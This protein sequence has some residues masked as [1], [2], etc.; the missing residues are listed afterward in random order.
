MENGFFAIENCLNIFLLLPRAKWVLFKYDVLFPFLLHFWTLLLYMNDFK[1]ISSFHFSFSDFEDFSLFLI[2]VRGKGRAKERER[3]RI[4]DM[5]EISIGCLPSSVW[6]WGSNLAPG[7]VPWLVTKSWT[8]WCQGRHSNP[9]SRLAR[10]KISLSKKL[11]NNYSH[12]KNHIFCV[13]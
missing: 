2:D 6:D 3:E 12:Q 4:L 8:L 9:L 11:N 5:R 13:L 7:Y 10:V 1:T